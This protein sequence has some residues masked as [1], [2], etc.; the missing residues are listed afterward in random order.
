MRMVFASVTSL[1][2]CLGAGA[3]L[4]QAQPQELS[5]PTMQPTGTV[6]SSA[7]SGAAGNQLICRSVVHEGSRIPTRDCRTRQQW[8][9]VR[10]L[11]QQVVNQAQMRGLTTGVPGH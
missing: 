9:T 2:L 6:N 4:A 1:G 11:N 7:S 5:Q 8:E 10:Y 3:A